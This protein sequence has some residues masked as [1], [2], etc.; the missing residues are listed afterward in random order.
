MAIICPNCRKEIEDDS[1]YCSS[2][3]IR[4]DD[5]IKNCPNCGKKIDIDAMF[6][7]HCGVKIGVNE[8]Q[9]KI[10][11]VIKETI[12]EKSSSYNEIDNGKNS[13]NFK[14]IIANLTFIAIVSIVLATAA[15]LTTDDNN[16]NIENSVPEII[17]SSDLKK[18]IDVLPFTVNFNCKCNNFTKNIISYLW[19]FGDGNYS[20][21]KNPVHVYQKYGEFP[22]ILTVSYI[23]LFSGEYATNDTNTYYS[24]SYLISIEKTIFK[25]IG[26]IKNSYSETVDV[27]YMIFSSGD[28]YDLGGTVYDIEPGEKDSFNFNVKEGFSSYT[29]IVGWFYPYTNTQVDRVDYDFTNPSA[30]DMIYNVEID[31]N[32]DIKIS[33][34]V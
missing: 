33:S 23:D 18:S 6:C 7:N 17:V 4:I 12:E 8:K 28:W 10:N 21:V 3:G 27:D 25:L 2:C 11:N 34:N 19:D 20:S 29:L 26:K 9:D 15:L 13:Q 16:E 5:F 22:V 1:D 32:G 14:P 24:N 31:S 30:E